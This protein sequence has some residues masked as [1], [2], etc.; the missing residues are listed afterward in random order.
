M[1]LQQIAGSPTGDET[2][3]V[4]P[5]AAPGRIFVVR[6]KFNLKAFTC[7]QWDSGSPVNS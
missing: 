4:S 5:A 2:D 3:I 7:E 1:V 6:N